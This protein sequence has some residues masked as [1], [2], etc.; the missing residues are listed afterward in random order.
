LHLSNRI[1][2]KNWWKL[3]RFTSLVNRDG[4]GG[5]GF[6]AV[7][8]DAKNSNRNVLSVG[9]GGVGLPDR[10]YYVSDDAD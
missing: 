6:W 9:P 3:E 10:D 4:Q 8:P 1:W 7:G 2:K 5:I